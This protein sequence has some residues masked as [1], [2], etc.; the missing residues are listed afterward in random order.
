MKNEKTMNFFQFALI[1][2]CVISVQASILHAFQPI[3]PPA[4]DYNWRSVKENFDSIQTKRVT[5]PAT[6]TSY[7]FSFPC[8]T[9][10]VVL[11]S[12]NTQTSAEISFVEPLG[13]TVNI[14]FK[15]AP[16]TNL[17]ISIFTILNNN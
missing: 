6:Y 8:D 17:D 13:N 7:V 11:A 5:Y 4:N 12:V 2:A 1:L 9:Y 14:G 3:I 15:T 10:S 16:S